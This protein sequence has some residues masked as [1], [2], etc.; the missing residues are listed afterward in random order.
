MIS[1]SE[2]LD[3]IK[4]NVPASKVITIK[5][6]E[7]LGSYC[8][9]DIYAPLDLPLFD[10]SAVDG[11]ALCLKDIQDSHK[12]TLI[13]TIRALGQETYSLSPQNCVKIMT[14][15]PLPLNAD[16]VI[17]KEDADIL[18]GALSFTRIPVLG[19]HIRKRGEDIKKGHLVASAGMRITPQLMAVLLG[20]GILEV[21]VIKK[22]RVVIICTGDELVE[23]PQKLKH[24]EVYFLV[25]PML[26][27]Q[28]QALGI[29]D[30]EVVRVGDSEEIITEHLQRACDADLVLVT[31]GMS[32][33]DYDFVRPALKRVGVQEIFY[34][35]CWRPG[36]PLYFGRLE[37]TCFFGLPGNPVACFVGLRIFVQAWLSCL[38]KTHNS[39]SSAEL[40]NNFSKPRDFTFFARAHVDHTHKLTIMPTQGSHEIF[41]LSQ[42]NALC[43]VPA[44]L[45]ELHVGNQVEYW[46]LN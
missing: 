9:C 27:A 33:G 10:N 36:K 21:R 28:F 34:Q 13:Q 2:A 7:A 40:V 38:F 6:S 16:C 26:Q 31:G 20:L 14:G 3:T 1:F 42:A 22:P 4:A 18:D 43:Y 41:S 19:A 45:S 32:K 24:G 8:A 15:A 44:G 35:G 29:E 5:L 37:N 11:F 30:I 46:P 25:G 39:L 23:A 17:M 12:I